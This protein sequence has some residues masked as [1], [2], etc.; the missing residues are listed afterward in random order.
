MRP[1]DPPPPSYT[2]GF[3]KPPRSGNAINGLGE[4]ERRRARVV[5]HAGR[6]DRLPWGPLD[7]FFSFINPWFVVR[8]AFFIGWYLRRADGPVAK[9]RREVTDPAAMSQP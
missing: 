2:F 3:R 1:F 9:S 6:G 7:D 5:F 4:S 8:H